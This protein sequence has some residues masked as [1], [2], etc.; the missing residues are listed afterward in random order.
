MTLTLRSNKNNE[1]SIF[2]DNKKL[3]NCGE[4][5]TMAYGRF[6][7]YASKYN[8]TIIS[9]YKAIKEDV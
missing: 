9:G 8:C 4:S 5:I 3:E 6:K 7:L 1:W 2:R